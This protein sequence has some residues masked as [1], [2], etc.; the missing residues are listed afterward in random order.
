MASC[1]DNDAPITKAVIFYNQFLEEVARRITL[2]TAIVI[3]H[4]GK[5][6]KK[7]FV[8]LA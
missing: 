5:V 2:A 8:L 4:R 7:G 1:F 6:C 3:Q